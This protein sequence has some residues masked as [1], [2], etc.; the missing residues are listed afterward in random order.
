MPLDQPWTAQGPIFLPLSRNSSSELDAVPRCPS[1][2]LGDALA[3]SPKLPG[4]EVQLLKP[5]KIFEVLLLFS[6]TT[7]KT[8]KTQKLTLTLTATGHWSVQGSVVMS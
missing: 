4:P 6:D 7:D 1:E 5:L 2:L 8:N 3:K